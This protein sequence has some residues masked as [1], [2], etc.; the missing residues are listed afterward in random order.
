MNRKKLLDSL[1]H[2]RFVSLES[3]N[4]YIKSYGYKNTV[5]IKN[6]F[7]IFEDYDYLLDGSLNTNSENGKYDDFS[8]W[9]IFDNADNYYITEVAYWND[10]TNLLTENPF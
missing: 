2:K 1:L 9:Y 8:I 7:E 4:D 6:E 5:V 10:D 3:I